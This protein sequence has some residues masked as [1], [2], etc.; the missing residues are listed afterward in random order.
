MGAF[1]TSFLT[2]ACDHSDRK[3]V[4]TAQVQREWSSLAL[5]LRG[6][7]GSPEDLLAEAINTP[8]YQN[9]VL[10]QHSETQIK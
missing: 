9:Q 6:T 2:F 4:K 1:V 7:A 8:S 5:N 10:N 3:G